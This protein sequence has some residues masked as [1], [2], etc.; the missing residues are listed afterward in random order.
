[1]SDYY[2]HKD[3]L[4]IRNLRVLQ[5]KT[6]DNDLTEKNNHFQPEYPD[7]ADDYDPRHKWERDPNV[8]EIKFK[9][10]EPPSW[11]DINSSEHLGSKIKVHMK[12]SDLQQPHRPFAGVDQQGVPNKMP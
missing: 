2:V 3:S 5:L 9:K 6:L 10:Y 1:M 8:K 11:L 4:I 7:Y 12:E